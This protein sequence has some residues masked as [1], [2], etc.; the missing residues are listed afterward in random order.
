ML[1]E[2]DQKTGKNSAGKIVKYACNNGTEA[3][4]VFINGRYYISILNNRQE[5]SKKQI[6]NFPGIKSILKISTPYKLVSREIQKK[7]TIFSVDGVKIGGTE[8]VIIAGPCAVESEKQ[9]IETAKSIKN[10]GAKLLRGGAFKPRT[11]PYDFQGMGEEGLKLLK[12]AREET[13]LPVISEVLDTSD[14]PLVSEY[15]DILQIGSRNMQNS[16]LLKEAGKL[17]KPV[18]LKRGMSATLPEFLMSAEYIMSGGNGRIILCERGIRTHADFSRNTLDLNVVPAL[19]KETH[20]P[21]FVD[22]SHGTGRS[23]LVEPMSLASLSAG[24]NGLM[25]EVHPDPANSLSDSDQSLN[26]GQFEQLMEKTKLLA[27][28]LKKVY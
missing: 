5:I 20:L 27:E 7:N 16:R 28:C 11:S 2:M 12:K 1:I 13:G 22:P 6:E 26:F 25:I 8:P 3:Q 9:I 4:S 23:D 18:L 17:S 14:I 19:Q 21:V 15:V 24:A 10:C